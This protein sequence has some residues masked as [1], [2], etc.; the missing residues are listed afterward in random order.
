MEMECIFWSSISIY[1][2]WTSKWISERDE[3][4]VNRRITFRSGEDRLLS[5]NFEISYGPNS[6]YLN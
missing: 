2:F 6:L 5:R 4:A 3:D 1:V